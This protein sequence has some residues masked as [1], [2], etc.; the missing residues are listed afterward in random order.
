MAQRKSIAITIDDLPMVTYHMSD[1]SFQKE[2]T[3]KLLSHLKSK[4]IMA[5]GFVN[6]DKLYHQSILAPIQVSLLR[7]WLAQGCELGNHTYSHL[8]YHTTP[9]D[10]Y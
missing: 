3:Q 8:D 6:E 4:K 9:F 7:C 10:V 2:V 1:T 5:T